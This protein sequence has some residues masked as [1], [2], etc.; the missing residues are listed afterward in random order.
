MLAEAE[1]EFPLALP[2]EVSSSA[3]VVVGGGSLFEF[4]FGLILKV[5]EFSGGE[6]RPTF[7]RATGRPKVVCFHLTIKDTYQPGTVEASSHLSDVGL[8]ARPAGQRC[9]RG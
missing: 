3:G 4:E 2:S 8:T 6:M 9:R 5:S 7:G 1:G